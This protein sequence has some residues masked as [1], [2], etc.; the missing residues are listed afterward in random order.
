MKKK[1]FDVHGVV[2]VVVHVTVEA[3]NGD[4]AIEKAA[5]KFN[6]VREYMGNGGYNKLIGVEGND[7]S[8][9]IDGNVEFDDY[10]EH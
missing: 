6:G 5:Q 1:K 10:T 2:P 4:E 9:T 7:E 8:I 3:D